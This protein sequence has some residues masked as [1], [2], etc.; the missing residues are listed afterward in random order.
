MNFIPLTTELVKI[1]DSNYENNIHM[2]DTPK[3]VANYWNEI[4]QFSIFKNK[5]PNLSDTE[6]IKKILNITDFEND[7]KDIIVNTNIDYKLRVGPIKVYSVCAHHLAPILG[8]VWISYKPKDKILGLSKL[9]RIAKLYARQPIIQE[10]YSNNLYK[11]LKEITESDNINVITYM[12]HLCMEA[13]GV[14]DTNSI[15]LYYILD[16]KTELNYINLNEK[17]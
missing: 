8:S 9:S 4:Y 13:R 7:D 5:Y 2:K 12:R 6:V 15:T 11:I 3:R 17:P 14:N 10:V 1:L 16:D